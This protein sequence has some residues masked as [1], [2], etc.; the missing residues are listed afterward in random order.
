MQAERERKRERETSLSFVFTRI[1]FGTKYVYSFLIS[2][3]SFK[4]IT[5]S[6]IGFLKNGAVKLNAAQL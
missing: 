5:C 4:L 3:I 2:V 1:A 6:E